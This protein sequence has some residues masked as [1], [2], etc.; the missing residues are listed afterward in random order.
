MHNYKKNTTFATKYHATTM[1]GISIL[2]ATILWITTTIT[3]Q[4]PQEEQ[5]LLD[6]IEVA[7]AHTDEAEKDYYKGLARELT[8][9]FQY[10]WKSGNFVKCVDVCQEILQIKERLVGRYNESYAQMQANLAQ[11][12]MYSGKYEEGRQ[13]ILSMLDTY[14]GIPE[15]QNAAFYLNNCSLVGV[16]FLQVGD[17]ENA[18]KYSLEALELFDKYTV[19]PMNKCLA[20]AVIAAAYTSLGDYQKAERYY[21]ED[22]AILPHTHVEYGK[23]LNNLGL[24]YYRMGDYNKSL[25]YFIRAYEAKKAT[26][27]E[28]HPLHGS[29]LSNI[30]ALSTLAGDYKKAEEIYFQ[31]IEKQSKKLNPR[32]Y[33]NTVINIGQLYTLT[34]DYERAL[35]YQ[36]EGI[37]TLAEIVGTHHMDYAAA[38]ST[39][40]FLEVAT[41]KYSDAIASL[42]KTLSIQQ[43]IDDKH[44][45]TVSTIMLLG[46]AYLLS[47][48]YKNAEATLKDAIHK[49]ETLLG[50]QHDHYAEVLYL[51]GMLY[52]QKDNLSKAED[53]YY[54]SLTAYKS[55]YSK[56]HPKYVTALNSLGELYQTHKQYA[57]AQVY[58]TQATQASKNLFVATTDYMSERQR[59]L[60]WETIRHRYETI[61]PHFAYDSFKNN[62]NAAAFAYDNELFLKGL[63][64]HSSTS[65]H[66]SIAN[67]GDEQLIAQWDSLKHMNVKILALQENDPTS[68]YLVQLRQEAEAL[69]KLL[70]VSSTIFRDNKQTWKT[71]WKTVQ[72]ALDANQVAIEF[73]V[74]PISDHDAI[75]C[76]LLLRANS[77]QPRLI[78]LCRESQ[79]LSICSLSPSQIYAYSQQG[80]TLYQLI[81]SPI[82]THVKQGESICFSPAG[83]LHQLALEYLPINSHTTMQDYYRL[84]RL[85]STREL[86]RQNTAVPLASAALYG[87]IQYDMDG[88]ELLAESERYTTSFTSR[89]VEGNIVRQSVQYLPGT[90]KEVTYIHDLLMQNKLQ[91]SLYL[92]EEGNEESFKSLDGTDN[93]ILHIATHGF[94]W[95]NENKQSPDH[96][97]Q[98]MLNPKQ[99]VLSI[100]PLNRCGLL[101]AGANL[102]LSGH[103]NELPEGVQ[104]GILTAKEISLLDLS[105]TQVAVL[106]ACETAAGEV[107]A[108]GVFGLQRGLKQAGVQTIIMSLWP[109]DDAATQLLMQHF[110]TN[111][112]NKQQDKRLAFQNAQTTVKQLYPNPEY[113][114]GFILLD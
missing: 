49:A 68:A 32:E 37:E 70:T 103:A 74:A 110:Y 69:E 17:F 88:D 19:E 87:G 13:V 5:A 40:A 113:W 73:F 36:Q 107:T 23:A 28:N 79:L 15:I 102:S 29:S 2:I 10:Y 27:P 8:P 54:Q 112:I 81:W 7:R 108:E 84:Q 95:S 25:E 63:L 14:Q 34:G 96:Y 67:S 114:A 101:L 30:A 105:H 64:L 89:S 33:A 53:Y 60:F 57:K 1:K 26:L 20:L 99:K 65:I 39:K 111:W 59:G 38:I 66:H 50:K 85:S 97:L 92:A 56:D 72:E 83:V 90:R 104:D 3:A 9:L 22:L 52:H 44:P 58:F 76:A 11:A 77:T 109:V 62:P 78:P 43:A 55:L 31:A 61:Y 93:H 75:Y 51:I 98:Q 16:F 4:I 47:Q 35:Q 48:D 91:S 42:L 45:E 94:F 41:G 24:L 12:Y 100:D 6:N 21:M 18:V 46:K 106:S 82:L 71:T 80:E 86:V